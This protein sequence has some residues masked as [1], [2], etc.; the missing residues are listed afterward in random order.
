M[1]HKDFSNWIDSEIGFKL[2]DES[3]T[4]QRNDLLPEEEYKS[5]DKPTSRTE[6]EIIESALQGNLKDIKYVIEENIAEDN[7]FY[8]GEENLNPTE[9]KIYN[10]YR[11]NVL[12]FKHHINEATYN[13]VITNVQQ[14]SKI[15]KI[16]NKLNK[17][18][19]INLKESEST[20]DI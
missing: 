18:L 15:I 7:M 3:D 17:Q 10:L 5:A 13:N 14:K 11:E 1:S 20:G 19:E 8:D 16:N 6:D 12:N 4:F 2:Q 9:L